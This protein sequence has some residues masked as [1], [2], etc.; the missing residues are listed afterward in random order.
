MSRRLLLFLALL[1]AASCG[2][3][4]GMWSANRFAGEARRLERDGRMA[5]ARASWAQAAVKAESVVSHNPKGRWADDALVLQG[6]GLAKSGACDRAAIPLA[7][8]LQT[9][10]DST[11]LGHAALVA[12]ECALAEHDPGKAQRLVEPLASKPGRE[13]SR[14]TYLMGLAAEQRGAFVTAA[15]WYEK[16]KEKD[17][18][19]ARARALLYAGSTESALALVDTLTGRGFGEAVWDSLL[20][21]ITHTTGA[22]IASSTLDA[23]FAH[24]KWHNGPRA[25]LLLADG[26]RLFA[27]GSLD[28]ADGRYAQVVAVV[29]DSTEGQQALVRQVHVDVARAATISDIA[30]LQARLSNLQHAGLGAVA[31]SDAK[32]L[33]G[34]LRSL[35]DREQDTAEAGAFRTA[36]LTRDSLR[37][38]QL[39][40]H[41]FIEFA[42]TYPGSIFAPK[43]IVAAADL[44]PEARD[45][46]LDVLQH[47]YSGS[48]YTL[49]VAGELS[50]GY[51]AAEDSLARALGLGV[52]SLA[53]VLGST[54]DLPVPGP[55]GPRLDEPRTS[56]KALPQAP[57]SG[58]RERQPPRSDDAPVRPKRPASNPTPPGAERP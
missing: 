20:A 56:G 43:A 10:R 31:A 18:G 54:I 55:R 41:L 7:R 2:Y 21:D 46:L 30:T 11:L 36:E 47:D 19:P 27:A 51:S 34:R 39:A 16:S 6:E 38:P 25:R 14:A 17:A 1:S 32:A 49:A 13:F 37:A 58:G 29:P 52:A 12:A 28:A 26:D 22:D 45:S 57:A 23:V 3:Y 33:E 24:N 48:P 35:V 4:N 15:E 44:A 50:P 5:D 53:P 42:T 8:A 40:A 9:V